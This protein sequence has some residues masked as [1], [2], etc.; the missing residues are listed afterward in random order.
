MQ[1]TKEQLRTKLEAIQALHKDLRTHFEP[2]PDIRHLI[3]SA[4]VLVEE[5]LREDS[6]VSTKGE[7]INLLIPLT[8]F[9]IE[10]LKDVVYNDVDIEWTFEA[11]TGERICLFF[12][13]EQDTCQELPVEPEPSELDLKRQLKELYEAIVGENGH[14]RFTHVELIEAIF[15]MYDNA[16]KWEES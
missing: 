12:K 1:H 2:S 15:E 16:K 11:D 7:P 3:K 6:L 9:D 10:I 4:D 8:A 14:K 13:N 5:L